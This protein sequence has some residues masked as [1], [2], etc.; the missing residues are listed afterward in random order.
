ML[1]DTSSP[2]LLTFSS[3]INAIRSFWVV[4]TIVLSFGSY[5]AGESASGALRTLLIFTHLFSIGL[6]KAGAEREFRDHD[7]CLVKIWKFYGITS[8]YKALIYQYKALSPTKLS[9]F[10]IYYTSK[11]TLLELHLYLL[12]DYTVCHFCWCPDFLPLWHALPPYDNEVRKQ[13]NWYHVYMH[14]QLL[15]ED[16]L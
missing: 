4:W 8:L 13:R 16:C 10:F 12:H 2:R 6:I 1:L 7:D 15:K 3:K 11:G 9:I 5:F 14:T